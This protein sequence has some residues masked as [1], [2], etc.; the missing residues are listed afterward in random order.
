MKR[1]NGAAVSEGLL[2]IGAAVPLLSSVGA[3]EGPRTFECPGYA[4]EAGVLMA[5]P[6]AVK[7]AITCPTCNDTGKTT[8]GKLRAL[9]ER[10]RGPLRQT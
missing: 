6:R 9:G 1:V 2:H 10:Y 8:A 7:L 3:A 5:C 4:P